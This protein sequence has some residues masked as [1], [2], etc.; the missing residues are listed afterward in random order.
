MGDGKFADAKFK[1]MGTRQFVNEA[2]LN[3]SGICYE[4]LKLKQKEFF[5]QFDREQKKSRLVLFLK[6]HSV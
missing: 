5:T 1:H 3:E 4:T 6:T 2:F